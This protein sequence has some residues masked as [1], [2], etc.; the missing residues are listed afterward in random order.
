MANE[1]ASNY[2]TATAQDVIDATKLEKTN[3]VAGSTNVHVTNT[4]GNNLSITVDSIALPDYFG[5]TETPG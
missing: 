3:I 2:R 5:S 4:T 1:T